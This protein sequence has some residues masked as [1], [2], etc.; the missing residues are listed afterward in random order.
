MS[1]S[2]ISCAGKDENN[3]ENLDGQRIADMI[4]EIN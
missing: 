4:L 2:E 1:E 3:V